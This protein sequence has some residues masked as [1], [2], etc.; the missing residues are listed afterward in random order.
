MP[1][2]ALLGAR[3]VGKTT[4]ARQAGAAW[5][6]PSAGFGLEVTAGRRA[7]GAVPRLLLRDGE[8]LVV[9]DEV[10]LVPQQFE[11]MRPVSDDPKRRI[12]FLLSG[13][14]SLDFGQRC[15]RNAGEKDPVDR[16]Q[17]LLAT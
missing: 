10:Q 3:Q 12:V 2:V 15:L 4:P 5:T 7:F 14:A 16:C 1:V 6:G 11:G 13:G 8:G 17:W 9:I